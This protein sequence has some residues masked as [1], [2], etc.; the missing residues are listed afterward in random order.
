MF[1]NKEKRVF[2]LSRDILLRNAGPSS[3]N[4]FIVWEYQ[5]TNCVLF[6]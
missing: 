2:V 3:L 6:S 4:T 1:N 5:R